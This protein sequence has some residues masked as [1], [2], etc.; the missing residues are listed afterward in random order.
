MSEDLISK[1]GSKGVIKRVSEDEG[2]ERKQPLGVKELWRH[3]RTLYQEKVG[4]PYGPWTIKQQVLLS[5]LIKEVGTE[6]AKALVDFVMERRMQLKELK[7]GAP[8]IPFIY[9]F[10]HTMLVKMDKLEITQVD[11]KEEGKDYGSW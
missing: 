7:G 1:W 2:Q 10:R 6:K 3:F 11:K 8:T 5:R 9:G 4:H